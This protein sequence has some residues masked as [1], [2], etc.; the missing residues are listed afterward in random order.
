MELILLAFKL[1]PHLIPCHIGVG[2]AIRCQKDFMLT[3]LKDW[4]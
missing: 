3:I 1:L 2:T 4:T